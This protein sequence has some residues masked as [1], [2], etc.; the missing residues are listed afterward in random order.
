MMTKIKICGLTSEEAIAAVCDAGADYAGFVFY[1]PS[2]RHLEPTRAAALAGG[3]EGSILKVA[4]TVD[5]DDRLLDQ[6][7]N[8]LLP[9][10]L[11]LQGSETPERVRELGERYG[12]AIMKAI[13]IENKADLSLIADYRATADLLLLDAKAPKS[14]RALPGGNGLA[15]DWGLISGQRIEDDWLLAGGLTAR[16][17]A[18]AIRVTG[19]PGVDVSSGVESAPGV[20]DPEMIREFVRAAKAA[21]AF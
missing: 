2:P 3:L 1:P 14:D 7:M 13:G 9:D 8:T 11:Q 17:V 10:V 5:A 18:E 20:K 6:I 12:R 19:A 15:F 4:L 16:N 21:T